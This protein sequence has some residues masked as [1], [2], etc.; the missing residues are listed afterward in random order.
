MNLSFEYKVALVN[1][2]G[3]GMRLADINENANSSAA[4]ELASAG[5]KTLAI[6]SNIADEA[7]VETMITQTVAAFNNARILSPA[8]E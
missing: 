1:G 6:R 2:G 8:I 7:D 5:P 3:M 4:E